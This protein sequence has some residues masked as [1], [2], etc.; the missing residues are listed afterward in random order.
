MKHLLTIL[1]FA[2]ISVLGTQTVAAQELSQDANRPEAVAK[3]Q[4]A[5]LDKELDL[6]GEQERTLFRAYVSNEI[7]YRKHINNKDLTDPTVIAN[8]TKFDASLDKIMKD[9]LTPTQYAKWAK[10]N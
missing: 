10:M 3:M 9:N 4:V 7:N 5:N 1:A 8:K 2:L 6:T